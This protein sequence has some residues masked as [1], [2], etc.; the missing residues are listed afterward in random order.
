MSAVVLISGAITVCCLVLA[1]DW[2]IYQQLLLVLAAVS[3]IVLVASLEA[4][5]RHGTPP[6]TE[7]EPRPSIDD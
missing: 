5:D 4:W 2:A 6:S 3:A 1:V 7:H